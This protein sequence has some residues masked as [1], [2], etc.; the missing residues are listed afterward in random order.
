MKKRLLQLLLC[1]A[2][3]LT[4]LPVTTSAATDVRWF[5]G[6]C[7]SNTCDHNNSVPYTTIKSSAQLPTEAGNY[8]LY[9]DRAITLSSYSWA[10]KGNVVLYM[11]D[12]AVIY[13]PNGSPTIEILECTFTLTG[14]AVGAGTIT[15][16]SGQL[17]LG[18]RVY[19]DSNSHESTFNMYH[20]TITGNTAAYSTHLGIYYH[21]GGVYNDGTFNMYGGTIS[22]NNLAMDRSA[23]NKK[24]YI[25]GGV[26]NRGVGTFNMYGGTITGNRATIGGGVF[27]RGTFNMSGG[28]ITQNEVFSGFSV[29]GERGGGMYIDKGGRFDMSGGSIRDNKAASGGGVYISDRYIT[30]DLRRPASFTLSGSAIIGSNSATDGGGIYRCVGTTMNLNGG[31]IDL[32]SATNGGG[33][34]LDGSGTFTISTAIIRNDADYGGGVYVKGDLTLKNATIG[35]GKVSDAKGNLALQQGGGVYVSGTLTLDNCTVTGNHAITHGGGVYVAN[36][37]KFTLKGGTITL[38]QVGSRNGDATRYGG[39][40]FNGGTMTMENSPTISLND[41]YGSS[42]KL[43][44]TGIYNGGTL[45]MNSGTIKDHTGHHGGAVYVAGGKTFTMNGGTLEGNKSKG[46]SGGAVYAL[47][48]FNMNGGTINNNST[49]NLG[50][51]VYIPEGG[52]FNMKNATISNCSGAHGGG[53]FNQGTF[54]MTNATISGC[55]ATNGTGHGGGL[56]THA[57]VK[58]VGATFENNTADLGGGVFVGE[59]DVL[60]MDANTKIINNFAKK[61]K[62]STFARGSGGGIYVFIGASL[63][64]NG[65]TISGNTA[66][67]GGGIGGEGTLIINDGTITNNTATND[68]GGLYLYERA[69]FTV[70]GGT[71]SNNTATHG[72]GAAFNTSPSGLTINGGTISGNKAN[73]GGGIYNASGRIAESFVDALS[74]ESVYNP[75][76]GAVLNLNG[77]TITGNTA[78]TCGGGV[79]AIDGGKDT[80]THVRISGTA[81]VV[82]NTVNSKANNIYLDGTDLQIVRSGFYGTAGITKKDAQVDKTKVLTTY[83]EYFMAPE[84]VS[85]YYQRF[86]S[87][88]PSF[89]IKSSGWLGC[90]HQTVDEATKKCAACGETGFVFKVV[91]GAQKNNA[92]NYFQRLETAMSALTDGSTLRLLAD[93]PYTMELNSPV[94]YTL[95]VNGKDPDTGLYVTAGTVT[96]KNCTAA[97]PQVDVVGG[98][99]VIADGTFGDVNVTAGTAVISGGSFNRLAIN[100]SGDARLS[101]GTFKSIKNFRGGSNGTVGAL[102]AENYGYWNADKEEFRGEN[103]QV[104]EN[105]TVKSTLVALEIA[106]ENPSVTYGTSCALTA[107]MMNWE[108]NSAFTYRWTLDGD[109]VAGNSSNNYTLPAN[110]NAG[111][112]IVKCVATCGDET[113]TATTKVTVTPKALTESDYTAPAANELGYD[114]S[115]QEL[116]NGGDISSTITGGQILFLQPNGTWTTVIPTGTDAGTYTI[117]YYID[118]GMNYQDV[119][120]SEEPLTVEVNIAPKTVEVDESSIAI[121]P[122]YYDATKTANV[123]SLGFKESTNTPARAIA[124]AVDDVDFKIV[125]AEFQSA[126]IGDNNKVE[127]DIELLGENY[128]FSNNTKET[129]VYK[130]ASIQPIELSNATALTRYLNADK[131]YT[132]DLNELIKGLTGRAEFGTIT[133]DTN[134]TFAYD[135]NKAPNA[136]PSDTYTIAPDGT[137]AITISGRTSLISGEKIGTLSLTATAPCFRTGSEAGIRLTIDVY[138]AEKTVPVRG[139]HLID[140]TPIT[141]GQPLSESRFA[142]G[143]YLVDPDTNAQV[144]GTFSWINPTRT[145]NVGTRW[146]E[147]LF[148][149]ND[150]TT[151]QTVNGAGAVTVN[152]ATPT[153]TIGGQSVAKQSDNTFAITGNLSKTYDGTSFAVT[154]K[155][156]IYTVEADTNIYPDKYVPTDVSGTWTWKQYDTVVSAPVN[157]QTGE[158]YTVTFTPTDT[159][160]YEPVTFDVTVTI[161]KAPLTI[162][163]VTAADRTYEPNN[164]KVTLSGGTLVGVAA[165][166]ISR[167]SFTLGE[168]TMNDANAGDDKTVNTNI[169]LIGAAKDNYTLTQPTVTVNIAKKSLTPDMVAMDASYLTYNGSEQTPTFTIKD[170]NTALTSSDYTVSVD[171]KIN[172]GDYTL[173]IEGQG[174]Y[175]DSVNI[176]WYIDPKLLTADMVTITAPTYNGST[177]SATITVKDGDTVLSGDCY[178]VSGDTSAINVGSRTLTITG[179]GNYRGRLTPTWSL[180]PQKITVTAAVADKRYDGTTNATGSVSLSVATL[181]NG[182]DYLYTAAFVDG[183]AGTNKA[184]YVQ[185]TLLNPNYCFDNGQSTIRAACTANITGT[186][187]GRYH[188]STNPS[189]ESAPTGDAGIA[190][191]AA[192]AL[193]ACTGS[194]LV[195]RRKKKS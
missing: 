6:T 70:N 73:N 24:D 182:I 130:S 161:N 181:K 167:V 37:A 186:S 138:L 116:V 166:D 172:A 192:L 140:K 131:T 126:D 64:L 101:G 68:G 38:N 7:G 57:P 104:V 10:P 139:D 84:V 128:N 160:N 74:K 76:K 170:G 5:C 59:P 62:N 114:G 9:L 11:D 193:S 28:E 146:A 112:H 190:L 51:G 33:L 97:T 158:T 98:K 56:C 67:N 157:V 154:A 118:G 88:D 168:G 113:Y 17:G 162:T 141:Y 143:S 34:Y 75:S 108:G 78:N 151:Y 184:A 69:A 49:G 72:G 150:I 14:P 121:A 106:S 148:T 89:A 20:G 40:V 47:G 179:R 169:T 45:T 164:V 125:R 95:D 4:L 43:D 91:S 81:S 111:E 2:L 77:G 171:A 86:A 90:A 3:C 123:V 82:G 149:P 103:Y 94:A 93:V 127:I 153:I 129:T 71:I 83:I 79:F 183:D 32:N 99:V 16:K 54:N 124:R 137:L 58:L 187:G 27:N 23:I 142:A 30:T 189:A 135:T 36:K 188:G 46:G 180:K 12:D 110:T 145:P 156:N 22:N 92:T 80:E 159:T 13:G 194:A 50:G 152:K 66:T 185:V 60:T 65:G 144:H 117:K 29:T 61:G 147:W 8:Y 132:Y 31:S 96:I 119:G 52:K 165:S 15:H 35:K 105:T 122:K 26:Y 1:A 25:G 191:Y 120:S 195:V 63:T 41:K 136:E 55:T 102:L 178:T 42:E 53:V 175:K 155:H 134:P 48:T 44:G 177:Q 107:T 109:E 100:G 39:G 173:T 21:G 133:W 18:V 176:P 19:G 85:Q 115:K 87:D 163:N 174:N